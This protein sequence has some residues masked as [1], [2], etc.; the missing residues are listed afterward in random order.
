MRRA[1]DVRRSGP[2]EEPCC[3]RRA[4]HTAL[5]RSWTATRGSTARLD[6]PDGPVAGVT[7]P[8]R[9]PVHHSARRCRARARRE[10]A[11][12]RGGRIDAK[13]VSAAAAARIPFRGRRSW[14]PARRTCARRRPSC[15]TRCRNSRRSSTVAHACTTDLSLGNWLRGAPSSSPCETGSTRKPAH[16]QTCMSPLAVQSVCAGLAWPAS[17][18]PTRRPGLQRVA[19]RSPT[20]LRTSASPLYVRAPSR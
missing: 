4:V 8:R 17:R 11:T 9:K 3:P 6:A 15:T 16:T 12:C 10:G 20:G 18:Q 14:W 13:A 1:C 5:H 2:A 7:A 19:A